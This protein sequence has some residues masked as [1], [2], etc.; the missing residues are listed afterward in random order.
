ADTEAIAAH[1][2]DLWQACIACAVS[3]RTVKASPRRGPVL[4]AVFLVSQANAD[5]FALTI[6]EHRTRATALGITYYLEGPLAPF[7][8]APLPFGALPFA[9]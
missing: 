2:R 3:V 8:F 5:A 9:P 7:T 1:V 6:S 4:S